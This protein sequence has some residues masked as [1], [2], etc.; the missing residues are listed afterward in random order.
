MDSSSVVVPAAT[1]ASSVA[2]HRSLGRHG[3]RTIAASED[4]DVPAFRSRYCDETVLLPAP[5]EDIT[6]YKDA[7]LSLAMRPDVQTIVPLREEDIYVLS[8]YRSEFGDHIATPWPSFDTLRTVHDRSRLFD[9]AREAGVAVPET[10]TLD[11]VDD[12][13]RELVVK[14][15]FALF[16]GDYVEDDS[17]DGIVEAGSTTFVRPDERPDVESL[18]SEYRHSP[19][20]QQYVR[21]TEYSFGVLYDSG[22]PV[23][24]TQ[25]RILRGQKYYCGPSVYHESVDV[26]ELEAA[27]RKLL[28][29][30]DWHGPADVDIIRD[31]E[32]GEFKLLEINPR[33]WATV[34]NEIHA[35][36]D[37]PYYYWRMSRDESEHPIPAT[38]S[39]IASHYL[40][41]ELSYLQSIVTENHPLC[42]RP[43]L[44][45]SVWEITKSILDQPR[46]DLLDVKD[47]LPF[48]TRVTNEIRGSK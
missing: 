9:A 14:P 18:R 40:M 48:V 27:G 1:A 3:V 46:F 7:L 35:G 26:P 44:R 19:H 38:E 17:V 32:T 47:P 22:D 33:F 5:R 6:E 11:E 28:D 43:P 45:S 31:E 41:G 20:V 13:D 24:T 4:E 2:F 16:T 39:G 21:G 34:S 42:D 10:R 8:K 37:F 36:F 30:L 12:W 25:K 23:V 15:R 29:Q